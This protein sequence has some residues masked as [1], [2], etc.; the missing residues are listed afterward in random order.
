VGA[1]SH[2]TVTITNPTTGAY[3]YAP[4]LNYNGTDS[5]TFK[6]NDGSLDSNVA[7]VSIH[8][9]S[10][11]RRAGRAGRSANDRRGYAE[12]RDPRGDRR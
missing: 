6:A 2:G 1:A 4:A 5:F 8:G 11:Q 7:T 12:D 3:S 9:Q 10:G